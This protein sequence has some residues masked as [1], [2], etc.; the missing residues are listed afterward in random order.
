MYNKVKNTEYLQ[1]IGFARKKVMTEWK[2]TTTVSFCVGTDRRGG[3][4]AERTVTIPSGDRHGT[5]EYLLFFSNKCFCS[6]CR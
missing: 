1:A 3:V 6:Y 2:V 4:D 5:S